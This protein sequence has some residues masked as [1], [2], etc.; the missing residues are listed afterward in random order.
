MTL[1]FAIERVEELIRISKEGAIQHPSDEE[2][3]LTDKH[4]L[5]LVLETLDNSV[6]KE[7]IAKKIEELKKQRDDTFDLMRDCALSH[8]IST[9]EDLVKEV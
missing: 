3:F 7:E 4:A 1:E 8:T 5:E 6:S 9:L 2:L